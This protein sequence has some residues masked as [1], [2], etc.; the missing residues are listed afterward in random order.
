MRPEAMS[1][2]PIRPPRR[3]APTPAGRTARAVSAPVRLALAIVLGP[4]GA[5]VTEVEPEPTVVL[6][7]SVV[8]FIEE[9][10]TL[11]ADRVMI[12]AARQFRGEVAPSV[13]RDEHVKTITPDRLRLENR[14][15][16]ML[17]PP[18][19]LSFRNLQ[20]EARQHIEVRFSDKSLLK[21]DVD[22]A[23]AVL[24]VADGV[25]HMEGPGYELTAPRIVVRND[26][27]KA[28]GED[29]RAWDLPAAL[30]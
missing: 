14:G 21:E 10:T 28:F 11:E 25:A 15:D 20:V 4:L 6:P 26:E 3:S 23:V 13:D 22:E 19:R 24:I 7:A 9:P 29:G 17:A 2:P 16:S 27:V 30:R 12:Q 18:V 1:Q 8:R 5:C